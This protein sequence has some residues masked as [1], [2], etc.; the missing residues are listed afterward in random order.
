MPYFKDASN[1]LFWLDDGDDPAV[2]LPQCVQISN[3]E[4]EVMIEA[5]R[6]TPPPVDLDALM[7]KP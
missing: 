2:W 3:E 4:A 5:N 1:K 7:S 6:I